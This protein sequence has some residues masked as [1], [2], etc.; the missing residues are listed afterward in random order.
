MRF[1]ED[2]IS[3]YE[4]LSTILELRV[5]SQAQPFYTLRINGKNFSVDT[6]RLISLDKFSYSYFLSNTLNGVKRKYEV[7]NNVANNAATFFKMQVGNS[8]YRAKL[9]RSSILYT[10]TPYF[11]AVQSQYRS[12]VTVSLP[13][14][15]KVE[16][17]FE[18]VTMGRNFLGKV[19]TP[20][21][22]L[23][24]TGTYKVDCRFNKADVSSKIETVAKCKGKIKLYNE[25]TGYLIRMHLMKMKAPMFLNIDPPYVIKGSKLYTNFFTEGDHLNLQRVIIKYLDAKFPWIITYDDCLL[26]RDLYHRF[27]MEE[28]G[29]THSAG[30]SVQGKEIVIT[31]L[32]VDRFKW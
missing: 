3:A 18:F 21:G 9:V 16:N 17:T 5:A 8:G 22:G 11:I 24:Q 7:F 32:T 23:E 28:Y 13:S 25:D 6:R 1:S 10:N 12:P 4:Q 30:G 15:I 26:V 14:E 27:H 31:N 2:E 29:I 20:I 19:L